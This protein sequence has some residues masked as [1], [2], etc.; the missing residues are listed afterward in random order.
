MFAA[1]GLEEEEAEDGWEAGWWR[2][3]SL[4]GTPCSSEPWTGEL[5]EAPALGQIITPCC[6]HL[7]TP[8]SSAG[9]RWAAVG[10]RAGPFGG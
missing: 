3:C 2:P 1:P 10:G 4:P 6:L 5:P 9:Q 7:G 8:R